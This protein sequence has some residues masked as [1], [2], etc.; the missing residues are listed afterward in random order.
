MSD[1]ELRLRP[2]TSAEP[3]ALVPAGYAEKAMASLMQLH[4]ELM[5]EKERRVELYR[6][7]MEKEQSV[8]ELRMYVK[9]L[10][11]QVER[12]RSAPKP[13][14]ASTA[15]AEA[16]AAP[17]R[18]GPAPVSAVAEEKARAVSPPAVSAPT[19]LPRASETRS[20][21]RPP[22]PVQV[23]R[24]AEAS[25][26]SKDAPRPAAKVE[27]V[28]A[29]PSVPGDRKAGPPPLP[30]LAAAVAAVRRSPSV[31]AAAVARPPE[32][33]PAPEPAIGVRAEDLGWPRTSNQ[34]VGPR[35]CATAEQ[36]PPP[37]SVSRPSHRRGPG[38]DGWKSW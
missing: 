15:F 28:A 7:L 31:V 6:Q 22:P 38:S 24:A 8:A 4:T 12:A 35:R 32:A 21:P 27:S 25:S 10:E 1:R 14:V 29:R 34:K 5:D 9:L 20:V 13:A 3:Q 16:K 26:P 30:G 19:G 2:S 23:E 11:D 33:A 36:L 37:P 18:K 17:V